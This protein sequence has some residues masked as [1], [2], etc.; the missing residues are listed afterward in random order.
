MENRISI[1]EN[2][3]FQEWKEKKPNDIEVKDFLKYEFD[4]TN[5]IT[6][7]MLQLYNVFQKPV[8][9]HEED[10]ILYPRLTNN[11]IELDLS[12]LFKDNNS[13]VYIISDNVKNYTNLYNISYGNYPISP[14]VDNNSVF[15]LDRK[16]VLY[17]VPDYRGERYMIELSALKPDV[18]I[19]NIFDAKTSI[20]LD[21]LEEPIPPINII[22]TKNNVIE[23][24]S[25]ADIECNLNEY[26]EQDINDPLNK[27]SFNFIV[28]NLST[29]TLTYEL[30]GS[31]LRIIQDYRGTDYKLL[32]T[33]TNNIYE[34]SKQTLT[35]NIYELD[36]FNILYNSVEEIG[37][38]VALR[39]N[40]RDYVR[41]NRVENVEYGYE[42]SLLS[43]KFILRSNLL[44]LT[45][46]IITVNNLTEV[47]INPDY[48]GIYEN[49]IAVN[50]EYAISVNVY[51]KKYPI[52]D[53]Q[54]IINIIELPPPIPYLLQGNIIDLGVMSNVTIKL[55]LNNFIKSSTSNLSL[56]FK[57]G[58][59]YESIP[60][61]HKKVFSLNTYELTVSVEALRMQLPPPPLFYNI[62]AIDTLYNVSMLE[63]NPNNYLSFRVQEAIVRL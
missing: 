11:V 58:M 12:K 50:A 34:T 7:S 52:Q 47:I 2:Y 4:P 21:I 27:I 25:N 42:A 19:Y 63:M 5:T 61:N 62:Y 15:V 43:Q 18:D 22:E 23:F 59:D 56:E 28:Q 32:I 36:P 45:I 17:I 54:F 6:L 24:M 31:I 35:L 44:D 57:A 60:T 39:F 3:L 30:T 10:I 37:R 51:D 33:A 49:G 13:L 20:Y 1:I 9:I 40:I 41:T 38:D 48:R 16:D 26:F 46:P 14:V 8:L 53:K 29:L 55:N